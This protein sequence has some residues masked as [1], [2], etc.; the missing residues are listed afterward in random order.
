MAELEDKHA[1]TQL[2]SGLLLAVVGTAL[3]ALKSIFIKMAYRYGVDTTTLLTLRMLIALPFYLVM[4]VW[5]FSRPGLVKPL[6]REYGTIFLLGFFGYYLA[7]YLD[8]LGLNY[9]TAQLERLTLYTY[10]VFTTLLSALILRELINRR[11][12]MAL[13][14]TY[15]GVFL[16]YWKET[17][18]GGANTTLGVALV[19]GSALSYSIYIVLA[20]PY[21]SQFG[22]RLFTSLAMLASTFY[23]IVQFLA[24]R[25]V[26]DLMIHREAWIYAFLLA[27][28]STVLPSFLVAEAVA[29][30]GAARTSIVGTAGPV[31][32][33][34]LAVVMLN[35]PFGIFHLIG[36]MMIMTG[37]GLLRK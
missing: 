15:A 36:M 34:L 25:S 10:P 16:L 8:L 24:T 9:I 18:I 13:A 3:F 23:I 17:H 20:K 2:R 12:V 11:I 19:I 26:T 21:I 32:T 31:V 28:V 30:I 37:V 29:R 22:S 14:L 7:S 6:P 1:A 5:I 35:E 4:L 33:I 27:F